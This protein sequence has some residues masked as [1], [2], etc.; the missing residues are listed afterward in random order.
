MRCLAR[1]IKDVRVGHDGYT[2]LFEMRKSKRDNPFCY[3]LYVCYSIQRE[4]S[5]KMQIF[6]VR[7]SALKFFPKGRKGVGRGGVD[8]FWKVTTSWLHIVSLTETG[9]GTDMEITA[10]NIFK[11]W[12]L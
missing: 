4:N 6:F 9:N 1:K 2:A 11:Q 3:V 10:P 5:Y 7:E 8:R 12:L